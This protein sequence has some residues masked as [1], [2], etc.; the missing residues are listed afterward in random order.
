[1]NAITWT[2]QTN[3]R[4]APSHR[5]ANVWD[6]T[7]NGKT[8]KVERAPGAYHVWDG[9]DW[10][11]MYA[12]PADVEAAITPDKQDESETT[13]GD[14]LAAFEAKADEISKANGW[15]IAR[16]ETV[17]LRYLRDTSP[18]EAATIAAALQTRRD[19]AA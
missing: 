4:N 12:T 9:L 18:A 19:L 8:Y 17:M 10:V 7:V 14:V 11:G 3:Y 15:T 2:D 6:V 1:M 13:D 5:Q 16:T